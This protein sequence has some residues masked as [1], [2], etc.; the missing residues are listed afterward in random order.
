MPYIAIKAFPKDEATV[1][2]LVERLNQTAIEVLGCP[3]EVLSISFEE[4][5]PADW[6]ERIIDGEMATTPARMMIRDGE[7]LYS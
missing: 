2:E 6:K 5:D 3:P 4:I 1:E 7:K